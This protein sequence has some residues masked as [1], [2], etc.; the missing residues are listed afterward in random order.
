MLDDRGVGHL[1]DVDE[2]RLPSKYGYGVYISLFACSGVNPAP[3]R[4]K[5]LAEPT[6]CLPSIYHHVFVL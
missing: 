3:K 1:V 6:H 5:G 2:L 4:G